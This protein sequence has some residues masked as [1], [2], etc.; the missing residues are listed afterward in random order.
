[1]SF[2][3]VDEARGTILCAPAKSHCSSRKDSSKLGSM[4]DRTPNRDIERPAAASRLTE[5]SR[6]ES[7]NH[8]LG[9]ANRETSR[10]GQRHTVKEAAE[11]LGITVDAVRG[12]LRRGTLDGVR[13]DGVVYVLLDAASHQQQSDKSATE[14]TDAPQQAGDQ[15]ELVG[16]LRGQIDWLRREVERKDTIIMQMAQRIPELPSGAPQEP[17]EADSEAPEDAGGYSATPVE[18]QEPSEKHSSWWR[19]FFG[20]EG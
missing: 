3:G 9:E 11:I 8:Q 10:L 19:R 20:F 6:D 7:A 14:S 4:Q 2:T 5:A 18:P 1:M 12:R 16:E 17:P 13:V 15:S